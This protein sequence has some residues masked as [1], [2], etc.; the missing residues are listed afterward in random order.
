MGKEKQTVE[1]HIATRG[2]HESVIVEDNT[3]VNKHNN[4]NVDI[5]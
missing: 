4:S 2:T 5:S 1:K 3:C